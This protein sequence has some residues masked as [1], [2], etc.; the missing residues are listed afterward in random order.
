MSEKSISINNVEHT[1]PRGADPCVLHELLRGCRASD[2]H[3]Q[4]SERRQPRLHT[5][6]RLF[7]IGTHGEIVE[8]KLSPDTLGPGS[9]GTAYRLKA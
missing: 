2:G 3:R 9:G 5:D 8:S 4:L 6:D 1:R 7:W